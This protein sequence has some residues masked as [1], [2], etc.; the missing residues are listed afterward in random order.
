[1]TPCV[2]YYTELLR[3]RIRAKRR[4]ENLYK[5]NIDFRKLSELNLECVEINQE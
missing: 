3:C 4:K 5:D 2:T 1:M